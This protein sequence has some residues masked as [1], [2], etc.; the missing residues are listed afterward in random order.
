MCGALA[1]IWLHQFHIWNS[2]FCMS[3]IPYWYVVNNVQSI[4]LK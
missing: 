4:G 3:N 1:F 2:N